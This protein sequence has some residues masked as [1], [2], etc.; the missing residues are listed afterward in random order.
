MQKYNGMSEHDACMFCT[1]SR[2]L[3]K[4][5]ILAT[6]TVAYIRSLIYISSRATRCVVSVP[7]DKF[8]VAHPHKR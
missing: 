8:I 4:I 5:K 1:S 3:G 2:I 6:Y 7:A